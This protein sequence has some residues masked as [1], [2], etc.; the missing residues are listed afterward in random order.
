MQLKHLRVATRFSLTA[1]AC[2]SFF[3]FLLHWIQNLHS[4]TKLWNLIYRKTQV[5]TLMEVHVLWESV[6]SST[7][8]IEG[9]L[10]KHRLCG[11]MWINDLY[12]MLTIVIH[13]KRKLFMQTCGAWHSSLLRYSCQNLFKE[14][15][16]GCPRRMLPALQR[17]SSS[18]IQVRAGHDYHFH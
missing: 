15:Q 3:F 16:R 10:S 17:W 1:E 11:S 4:L 18:T 7:C 14:Q 13:K 8:R 9:L 12:Q 5:T 2:L 6:A